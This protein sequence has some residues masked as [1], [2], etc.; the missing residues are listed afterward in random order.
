MG[1]RRKQ[2]A[3]VHI[4]KKDLGLDDEAYRGHIAAIAPTRTSAKDLSQEQL[5][6]L[7]CLREPIRS[8]SHEARRR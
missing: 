1:M 4:A 6:K 3:L 7:R 5:D 2:L 8:A